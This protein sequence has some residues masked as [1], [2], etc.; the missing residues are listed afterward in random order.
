MYEIMLMNIEQKTIENTSKG[1][2][3]WFAATLVIFAIAFGVLL[4][5]CGGPL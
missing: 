2:W 1:G 5:K 4:F 3:A